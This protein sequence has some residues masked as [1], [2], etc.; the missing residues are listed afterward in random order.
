[1]V[2][3]L[4]TLPSWRHGYLDAEGADEGHVVFDDDDAAGAVDF[5]EKFGGLLG[6]GVGHA[7]YRF[8]DEEEAEGFWARSMPISSHCFWPWLRSPARRWRWSRRRMVFEDFLDAVVLR[9]GW[10]AREGEPGAA[11][12][13]EGEEEVV[14]DGVGLEDGGFLELAADAEGWRCGVRRGG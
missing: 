9:R 14:P 8:V 11:V 1:M 5:H 7:G 3:S 4:S 12:A 13:F 10:R 2:P 6:F